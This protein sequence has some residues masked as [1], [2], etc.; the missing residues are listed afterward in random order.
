M[1]KPSVQP[2]T[3]QSKEDLQ[4]KIDPPAGV[5]CGIACYPLEEVLGKASSPARWRLTHLHPTERLPTLGGRAPGEPTKDWTGRSCRRLHSLTVKDAR[6]SCD[7]KKKP[8][9]LVFCRQMLN[10]NN[11]SCQEESFVM[12]DEINNSLSSGLECRVLRM[13]LLGSPTPLRPTRRR[14]NDCTWP[15]LNLL[16]EARPHTA[17][18]QKNRKVTLPHWNFWPRQR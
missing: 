18:G 8:L 11:K 9:N 17:K 6:S 12:V 1:Q 4:Q 13:L 5:P 7:E 16:R 15:W 2:L 10:R 3:S 14:I